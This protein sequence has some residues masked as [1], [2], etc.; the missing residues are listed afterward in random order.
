M[1]MVNCKFSHQQSQIWHHQTRKEKKQD[2]QRRNWTFEQF[3]VW[4]Q[5]CIS[6]QEPNNNRTSD[7]TAKT[8]DCVSCVHL[9]PTE[10]GN[11]RSGQFE[12][13]VGECIFA[14]YAR[15]KTSDAVFS[16]RSNVCGDLGVDFLSDK[17]IFF[18]FVCE[19]TVILWH[20]LGGKICKFIIV[21]KRKNKNQCKSSNKW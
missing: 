13:R 21:I 11:E 20:K 8:N 3:W 7:T 9:W 12:K 19:L 10:G 16:E 1:H 4:R 5:V 2:F 17:E 15:R 6:L 18:V 14:I